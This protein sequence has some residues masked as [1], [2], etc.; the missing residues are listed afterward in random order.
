MMM[1]HV[2]LFLLCLVLPCF[3]SQRL[4]RERPA[5]DPDY[6]CPV[7]QQIP[8]YVPQNKVPLAGEILCPQSDTTTG[9]VELW[10]RGFKDYHPNVTILSPVNGSGIAGPCLMNKTCNCAIIAR[11]MLLKEYVPYREKL[12]YD[13]VEVAVSGGSYR[14]LAF[15]D[16]ETFFVNFDNPI[17]PRLTFPQ[18]DAVFSKTRRRGHP[19]DITRWGQ[20]IQAAGHEGGDEKL[21]EWQNAPINL[22]GVKIENGFEYYLNR[23]ILL[24]GTWK[25]NI[26]TRDTVFELASLVGK[27]KYGIGYAG[28]AYINPEDK[29]KR[30]E[31][32]IDKGQ[33]YYAGDNDNICNRRYPLSRLV[34]TYTSRE[35]GRV[36]NP[37]VNE[38]IRYQLSYEGQLAVL[39]DHIFYPLTFPVVQAS[40][41]KLDP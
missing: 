41:K 14:S 17:L 38:F 39:F 12:G 16:A 10:L 15:T 37:I 11:E 18:I 31:L 27:D 6:W 33:P 40:L 3:F 1:L 29:V 36:I 28:I 23:T 24:G 21:D 20:L 2:R 26:V 22:Y 4:P 13:P 35:P 19:T 30:V 5:P 8:S 7:S 25:D 9:L 32:A 34:F